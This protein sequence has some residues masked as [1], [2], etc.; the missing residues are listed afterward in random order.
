MGLRDIFLSCS[1]KRNISEILKMSWKHQKS[2]KHRF[3]LNNSPF[4]VAL[5]LSSS[6]EQIFSPNTVKEVISSTTSPVIFL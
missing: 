4:H 3:L 2:W 6:Q 5:W 1:A